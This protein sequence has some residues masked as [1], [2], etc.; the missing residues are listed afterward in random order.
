MKKL[1]FD[2]F[3]CLEGKEAEGWYSEQKRMKMSWGIWAERPREV[4]DWESW[5]RSEVMASGVRGFTKNCGYGVTCWS[6]AEH[7]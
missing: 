1:S 5:V 3:F 2:C 7:M 6:R 4:R